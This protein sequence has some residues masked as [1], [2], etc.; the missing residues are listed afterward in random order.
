MES[1]T[2]Y[3]FITLNKQRVKQNGRNVYL[4]NGQQFELELFNPLNKSVLAKIK[5]NG[6]YLSGGGIVVKPGQRIFLERH[7]DTPKK[8][9]YETYEVD[10]TSNEVLDA[11]RSNGDVSVEFYKEN[12]NTFNQYNGNGFQQTITTNNPFPTWGGGT[13]NP[14]YIGDLNTTSITSNLNDISSNTF[15]TTSNTLSCNYSST[16]E[17]GRVE[18][19]GHSNQNFTNVN[20]DFQFFKSYESEW[21]ILP[22]SQKTYESNDLK[23]YCGDCGS[24]RKKDTHKFCP[25]CG[26]KY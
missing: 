22:Y 16:I 9:K 21:K 1:G 8:F 18:K 5:L 2:P 24:R 17:T 26:S 13:T 12:E 20:T 25:N 10:G 6:N 19:G 15:T 14:Y 7:L 3:A 23:V 4:K 11:I